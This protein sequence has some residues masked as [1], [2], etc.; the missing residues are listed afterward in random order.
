ML[1]VD[2]AL[3]LSS[4]VLY[5]PCL[6]SRKI[7]PN[8]R[9]ILDRNESTAFRSDEFLLGRSDCSINRNL[10]S[11]NESSGCNILYML[12]RFSKKLFKDVRY[13]RIRQKVLT[14]LGRSNIVMFPVLVSLPIEAHKYCPKS[15]HWKTTF[16][17][18]LIVRADTRR[19][20]LD[21]SPP[22]S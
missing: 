20:F 18:S 6:R 21:P 13:V 12:S 14:N 4:S 16:R 11:D 10:D 15:S 1:F 7:L 8:I 9:V 17:Q 3:C 19:F 2:L 5:D 22:A